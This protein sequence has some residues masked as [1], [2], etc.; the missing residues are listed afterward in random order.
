MTEHWLGFQKFIV[1]KGITRAELVSAYNPE[2]ILEETLDELIIKIEGF[3]TK[4]SLESKVFSQ[5]KIVEFVVPQNWWEQFKYEHMDSWWAP[6]W[7]TRYKRKTLI[8]NVLFMIE[9]K[10][11]LLFPESTI[12][13]RRPDA[14]GRPVRYY[15]TEEEWVEYD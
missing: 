15:T 9:V 12:A 10:P 5:A 13:L 14:L 2:V 4:E 8:R 3:V 6:K 1:S 11:M 7:F